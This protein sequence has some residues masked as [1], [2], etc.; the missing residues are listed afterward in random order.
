MVWLLPHK[1]CMLVF[2]ILNI[3]I[4]HELSLVLSQVMVLARIGPSTSNF[5]FFFTILL[6]CK[7]DATTTDMH[8]LQTII[9]QEKPKT[10]K[11]NKNYS[12]IYTLQ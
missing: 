3:P 10:E 6:S 9:Q 12:F 5:P 4:Q 2:P 1:T 8:R 7:K 11:G